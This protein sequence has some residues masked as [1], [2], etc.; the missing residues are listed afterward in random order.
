MV[1]AKRHAH[2]GEVEEVGVAKGDILVSVLQNN[3]HK[4]CH[5]VII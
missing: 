2:V 1:A 5:V 4:P 3:H